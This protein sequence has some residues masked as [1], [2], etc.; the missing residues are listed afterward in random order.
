MSRVAAHRGASS[1]FLAALQSGA[2]AVTEALIDEVGSSFDESSE[3]FLVADEL[4]GGAT[5]IEHC[6]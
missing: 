2:A 3:L 4:S 1:A 6:L 5:N